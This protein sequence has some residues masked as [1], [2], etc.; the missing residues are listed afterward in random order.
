MSYLGRNFPL[1]DPYSECGFLGFN[2][3]HPQVRE[4]LNSVADVYS[5]G[6]IFSHRQWHDSWIWD[7]VRIQ[8]E[9]KAIQFK[10]ISGAAYDTDHPFIN[11]D[12]GNFF[13][14]LKGPKRKE[15]GKSFDE[16]YKLAPRK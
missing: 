3:R 13:D 14:H 12:L 2:W 9:R 15:L 8:F 10:N 11:S 7:Q 4:F 6:E 5:S 16:D 1:N